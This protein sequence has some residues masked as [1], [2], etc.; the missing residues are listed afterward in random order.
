ME[1]LHN[2]DVRL[3]TLME[4]FNLLLGGTVDKE[5]FQKYKAVF[6]TANAW[7]VNAVIDSFLSNAEDV[8]NLELPI[9]RFIRSSAKG[10]ESQALAQY[11]AESLFF[12][13]EEENGTIADSCRHL[14]EL[15]RTLQKEPS[16]GITALVEAIAG[17]SLLRQ[18]YQRLQN[19]LFP[20]FEQ[21]SIQYNCVKLMWL[22][23]DN[24]LDFQKQILEQYQTLERTSFWAL[25]GRFYFTVEM[26]RYREQRI[27]YPVAYRSI[28]QNGHKQK[29]VVDPTLFVSPSGSL[30]LEQLQQ[31]FNLLPLDIS[32]IDHED[33]LRFYSDPPHRIFP[34]TPQ[35][36]G[37]LVQ[38][39]HPPKSV[40][41]VEKILASFKQGL[42]D[43]AEFYLQIQGRFVHIQYYAVR[44]MDGKYLGTLEVSQDATHL[45][46]LHGEK[47]LL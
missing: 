24:A 36:L 37:R 27:L 33:R 32:F 22:L 29:P 40:A 13:L 4:Y 46:G 2:T 17:F 19:E 28:V 15:S 41:T 34:R 23:Q 25:F 8:G 6:E 11:P 42:S 45:R 1:A 20:L 14:Q 39:C 16:L 18:H 30:S 47:R 31:I 21:S 38:N 5:T 12:Q 3:A 43:T 9:S 7:E 26:L 44:S 35:V 10:L